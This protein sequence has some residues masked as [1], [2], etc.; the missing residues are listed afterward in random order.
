MDINS[1]V[2]TLGIPMPVR[3]RNYMEHVHASCVDQ[4]SPYEYALSLLEDEGWCIP[5][6][7]R[8]WATCTR[9]TFSASSSNLFN[10]NLLPLH[11][12]STFG[13]NQSPVFCK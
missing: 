11:I 3:C 9:T 4:C 13:A 6:F 7:S 1:R 12:P 5:S 10:F 2:S 8:T